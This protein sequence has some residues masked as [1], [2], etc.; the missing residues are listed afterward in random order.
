MF[1][2][3]EWVRIA[4]GVSLI[5]VS[6]FAPQ[7][8]FAEERRPANGDCAVPDDS[9]PRYRSE[10]NGQNLSRKLDRCNGEL[11]APDVGDSDLVEPAPPVGNTPV[12]RPNDLPPHRNPSNNPGGG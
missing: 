10:S 8:G 9:Q 11:K 6:F 7:S 2:Q 12:I 1:R 3:R 5:A 4:A